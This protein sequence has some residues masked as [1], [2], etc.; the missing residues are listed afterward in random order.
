MNVLVRQPLFLFEVT[1]KVQQILVAVK[2]AFAGHNDVSNLELLV[3]DGMVNVSLF[4][5]FSRVNQRD[6]CP[7]IQ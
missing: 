3:K 2:I 4:V 7:D 6:G 5:D 1:F